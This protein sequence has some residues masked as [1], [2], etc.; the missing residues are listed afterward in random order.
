MPPSYHK[1]A[2]INRKKTNEEPFVAVKVNILK[3]LFNYPAALQWFL[4]LKETDNFL[5]RIQAA[6]ISSLHN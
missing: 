1:I 4:P 6:L 5:A 3:G 2:Q